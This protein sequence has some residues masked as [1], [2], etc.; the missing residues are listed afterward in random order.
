M[1][2]GVEI[3]EEELI[4][5]SYDDLLSYYNQIHHQA[6]NRNYIRESLRMLKESDVEVLTSRSFSSYDEQYQS[7]QAARDPN[8][9]T[10]DQFLKFLY[11]KGLRL[12]DE[13]QPIIPDMY[14]R[15]DFEYKPNIFVFCD[16]TPHDDPIVIKDDIEKRKALN[17]DGKYQV[18]VWYYKNSLDDF[19]TNRPDVFKQVRSQQ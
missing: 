16:G 18:L 19:V 15:P 13:A 5:A 12:P 6:I 14:V 8:S 7:L 11:K 4:P 2:D 1:K 10:E 9:S 17:D 3:P